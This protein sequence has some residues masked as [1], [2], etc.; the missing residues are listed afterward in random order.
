M[1]LVLFNVKYSGEN[2]EPL[3]N[4]FGFPVR[5]DFINLLNSLQSILSKIPIISL[6]SIPLSLKFKG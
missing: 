6:R 5:S 1:Y 4:V 2:V 3:F